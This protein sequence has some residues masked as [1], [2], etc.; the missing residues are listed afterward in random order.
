MYIIHLKFKRIVSLIKNMS[1]LIW[2]YLRVDECQLLLLYSKY[3]YIFNIIFIYVIFD[4]LFII[5]RVNI[6]SANYSE[7]RN[8]VYAIKG[9]NFAICLIY[10]NTLDECIWDPVK[11][12]HFICS[13]Y[14]L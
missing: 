12:C 3:I 5:I 9:Y 6:L 8:I 7:L 4:I 2:D 1:I 14:I 10:K 11:A 13:L